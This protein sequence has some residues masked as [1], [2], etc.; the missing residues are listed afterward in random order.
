MRTEKQK[1]AADRAT[2][3]R[4]RRE[5]RAAGICSECGVVKSPKGV[6]CPDCRTARAAVQSRR[7]AYFMRRGRCRD[8]GRPRAPGRLACP[9]CLYQRAMWELKRRKS[10]D[11]RTRCT[12]T[13]P[14]WRGRT[15]VGGRQCTHKAVAG[16]ERCRKHGDS[17][18]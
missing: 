13:V 5:R 7:R 10:A 1:L 11:T 3:R 9:K 6:T 2:H 15:Q 18:Q 4:I 12:G 16:S 14:I 17:R 8:C